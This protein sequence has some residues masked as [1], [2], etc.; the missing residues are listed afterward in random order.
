VRCRHRQLLVGVALLALACGSDDD[1]PADAGE[2]DTLDAAADDGAEGDPEEAQAETEDEDAEELGSSDDD[3]EPAADPI[4]MRLEPVLDGLD[5]PNGLADLGDGRLL[6]GDQAGR[7][8]L[9]VDGQ[10]V[11]PP[12]LDVTDRI[13]P[14]A[15]TS[16]QL[17]LGLSGF[18]PHPD[19]DGR[20]YVLLTEP[21]PDDAEPGTARVDVLTEFTATGDPWQVDPA[22]ERELL[23]L[24]QPARDHVG[25]HMLFGPDGLLYVGLGDSGARDE[26]PDP[27]TLRGTV[28]RIDPD[29]GDPYGVPDD[30]PFVDGGGAPEVYAFGFRNPFRVAWLDDAGLLVADPKWTNKDQEILL[31][32]PG[33]DYGWPLRPVVL[34]GPS[35]FPSGAAPAVTEC[36]EGPDGQPWEP[37]VVEYGR[38]VGQIV[39]GVAVA[40]GQVEALQGQ[41]VVAD[42]RGAM[43][44]ATPGAA[45]EP[46]PTHPIHARLPDGGQLDDV[47]LWSLD[48]DRDG[49]VYV[50]TAGLGFGAGEGAVYRLAVPE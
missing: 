45:G 44:A 20:I 18:A 4:E 28:I 10:R 21:P 3:L 29:G 5:V 15:T 19:G 17:E 25:G 47:Y 38:D 42:W 12:V 31:V 39:S 35:C 40:D 34:P 37:P 32:A 49:E 36:L 46:W 1:E 14:P 23:R 27:E 22:S 33:G 26:A 41:V 24:A 16:N 2:T 13:A 11:E 8:H 9:V 50:F 30:N 7:L 6:V 43:L 48:A